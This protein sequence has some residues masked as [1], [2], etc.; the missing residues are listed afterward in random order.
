[1]A[2]EDLIEVTMQ[3]RNVADYD[4]HCYRRGGRCP[5]RDHCCR[6]ELLGSACQLQLPGRTV[7]EMECR[8]VEEQIR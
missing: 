1:L 4:G 7:A 8:T 3:P 5:D 6:V 2:A